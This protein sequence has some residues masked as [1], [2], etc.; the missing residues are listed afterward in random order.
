M[1]LIIVVLC[2]THCICSCPSGWKELSNGKCVTVPVNEDGSGYGFHPS[3]TQTCQAAAPEGQKAALT[4][5]KDKDEHQAIVDWMN[6][7]DT[8]NTITA[9]RTTRYFFWIGNYQPINTECCDAPGAWNACVSGETTSYT[10]WSP[11]HVS[12]GY[13]AQPDDGANKGPVEDCATM[14]ADGWYDTVCYLETDGGQYCLCELGLSASAAY[15][16]FSS[17]LV[18][19]G[20]GGGGG[21]PARIGLGFGV[22]FIIGLLPGLVG[23]L[24]RKKAASSEWKERV[25][26]RVSL[27]ML[28]TGWLL[29][30]LSLTPAVMLVAGVSMF[31]RDFASI[32]YF[33]LMLVQQPHARLLAPLACQMPLL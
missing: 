29:V 25:R 23:A 31:L 17:T 12:A 18:S 7:E 32:V 26:S 3:C 24:C 27:V 28:S 9:R 14:T 19:Q 33:V 4:C 1:R 11:T 2:F 16:N 5:V 10:N 8:I 20:G 15:L 6:A 13:A 22:A 21:D 30:V